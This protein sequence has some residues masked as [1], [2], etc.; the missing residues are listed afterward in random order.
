VVLGY[1]EYVG[2]PT[3]PEVNYLLRPKRSAIRAEM[4]RLFGGDLEGWYL[5]STAAGPPRSSASPS[6]QP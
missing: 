4:A 1:P 5:G 6:G 2:E 3:D